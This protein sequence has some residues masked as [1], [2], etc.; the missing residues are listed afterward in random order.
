MTTEVRALSATEVRERL[1]SL[2]SLLCNAVDGGA[3]V[4]FLRPLE[5]SR[6][7][8]YWTAAA[9]EVESGAR[10]VFAAFDDGRLIGS[11]QFHPGRRDNALQRGEIQKLLVVSDARMHGVAHDLMRVLE[12]VVVRR[13]VR[14]VVTYLEVGSEAETLARRLGYVHAG[15][16][17]EYAAD[18]DGTLQPCGVWYKQIEGLH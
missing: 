18:A 1:P 11:V 2:V 9:D 8:A 12:E 3:S 7:E 13:G 4:G 10:V 5:P 16:I 6:A 17:P 14:L 15:T